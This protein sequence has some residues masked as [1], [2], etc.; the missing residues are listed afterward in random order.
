MKTDKRVDAYILRS[1]PFAQPILTYLRETVHKYCPEAVETIKW[2]FPHFEY[3]GSILASMA[4][5]KEHCTFGFWLAS[6]ID[7]KYQILNPVGKTAMGH[8]GRIS[9]VKDLPSKKIMGEYIKQAV[10]LIDKGVKLPKQL[11]TKQKELI[12]PDDLSGALKKNRKAA[13]A[14]DSFSSTNKKEYVEWITG[15]KT[16]AT[17][18]SRLD[19]A[20]EWMSEGKI[21]N[22]KY[23]RK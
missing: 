13:A 18:N 16:E 20:M 9:S 4:S 22:W 10:S 21:K 14:F 23:E 15:A 8:F 11:A 1:A 2:N 12:V 5:F 3:N 6:L 19:T 17:R 7:D